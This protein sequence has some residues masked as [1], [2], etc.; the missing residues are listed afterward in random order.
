MENL[1]LKYQKYKS[2]YEE[3]NKEL[4]T[5]ATR[6][7]DSC[8]RI[9]NAIN[10]LKNLNNLTGDAQ[11]IHDKIASIPEC[12]EDNV[13]TVAVLIKECYSDLE[14]YCTRLLNDVIG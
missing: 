12:T 11:A 2:L 5:Y 14:K 3:N 6:V 1:K 13:S 7:Q 8:T 9:N 4:T 10:Q